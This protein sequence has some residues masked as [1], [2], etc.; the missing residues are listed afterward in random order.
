MQEEYK[1][2]DLNSLY[3]KRVQYLVAKKLKKKFNRIEQVDLDVPPFFPDELDE[4][5]DNFVKKIKISSKFKD[6]DDEFYT[7]QL[8]D[9]IFFISELE[10]IYSFRE[11]DEFFDEEDSFLVEY[12]EYDG[13]SFDDYNLKELWKISRERAE[14]IYNFD[15]SLREIA[16]EL[17]DKND[18]FQE[19]FNQAV[20]LI[21]KKIL[22]EERILLKEIR[23]FLSVEENLDKVKKL[24][25][26][27]KL[28]KAEDVKRSFSF[29]DFFI[30]TTDQNFKNDGYYD[31]YFV[32]NDSEFIQ[33]ITWLFRHLAWDIMGVVNFNNKF[34]FFGRL[35]FSAIKSLEKGCE[36]E[37]VYL[38]VIEETRKI[39]KDWEKE[40]VF[41]SFKRQLKIHEKALEW[42]EM[43]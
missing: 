37:T 33:T 3:K 21:K 30:I 2:I 40:M 16:N 26:S 12:C 20:P 36:K 29:K 10:V 27:K 9:D 4:L 11:K 41:D 34:E 13:G 23:T 8:I 38:D 39:R 7:S 32:T 42:I 22:K 24:A 1:R 5:I 15:K 6:F 17:C 25:K 31:Q 43:N 35:G 14:T 19:I 28:G 18:F